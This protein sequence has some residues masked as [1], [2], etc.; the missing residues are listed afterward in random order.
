MTGGRRGLGF[1]G[2]IS[3]GVLVVVVVAAAGIFPFRQ[4]IERQESVDLA[5]GKLQALQSENLRLQQQMAALETPEEVE[6][7]ARE[8]FGLVQ[9]GEI[10]FVAVAP[11]GDSVVP[12]IVEEPRLERDRPWWEE[13]WDFLSGTD[14][15]GD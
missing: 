8:Q 2:L 10:G 13:L 4:I 3:L 12:V 9:P 6:R 14:V 5:E 11:E 7:I 15:A 1:G